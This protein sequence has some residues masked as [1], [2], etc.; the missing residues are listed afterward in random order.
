MSGFVLTAVS[1]TA[2]HSKAAVCHFRVTKKRRIA[3]TLLSCSVYFVAGV[4]GIPLVHYV[5]ERGKVVILWFVAVHA[6][7]D[8]NKAYLLLGEQRKI[9]ELC[10]A[11]GNPYAVVEL[12][13]K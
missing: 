9:V 13:E 10:D 2:N 12:K 11:E 3:T 7:I 1:F 6:V 4:L 8:C 5:E